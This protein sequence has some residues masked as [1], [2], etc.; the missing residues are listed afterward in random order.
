MMNLRIGLHSILFLLCSRLLVPATVVTLL[1][2]GA[3]TGIDIDK[4]NPYFD[5]LDGFVGTIS[6]SGEEEYR[7]AVDFNLI[8]PPRATVNSAVLTFSVTNRGG[9]RGLELNLFAGGGK[10]GI[11]AIVTSGEAH[12][13]T[14]PGYTNVNVLL[15]VSAF[16]SNLASNGAAGLTFNLREIGP[17]TN[18]YHPMILEMGAS[19]PQL[20]VD[21]TPGLPPEGRFHYEFDTNSGPLVYNF[22][23]LAGL[24]QSASGKLD[25]YHAS[26]LVHGTAKGVTVRF[27]YRE[28]QG[29]GDYNRYSYV[30]SVDPTNHTLSGIATVRAV[31]VTC[32]T[33]IGPCHRHTTVDKS[34]VNWPLGVAHDG[35]WKLDLAIARNRAVLSGNA[36]I[37]FP[38]GDVWIFKIRGKYLEQ[39]QQARLVMSNGPGS[40]LLVTL[41]VP[42]MA[43]H[44]IRGTLAGQKISWG[45]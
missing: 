5:W 1:P 22:G 14:V 3:A 27:A 40:S 16:V 44:N 8:V 10:V 21:Y 42:D 13:W 38:N 43:V 6:N 15:D 25:G 31:T 34:Y 39:K 33:I 32:D 9:P 17:A 11:G 30:M 28:S 12:Q 18:Y 45:S 41:S 36:F 37:T 26:G 19:E 20:V 24:V 2:A 29:E 4:R 23:Q 35:S 7:T